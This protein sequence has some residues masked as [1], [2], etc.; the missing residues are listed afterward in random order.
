M[1]AVMSKADI[2]ER[3]GIDSKRLS[4]LYSAIFR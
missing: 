4:I 3:G 1:T 2:D